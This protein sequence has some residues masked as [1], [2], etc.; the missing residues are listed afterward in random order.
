MSH[1]VAVLKQRLR[2]AGLDKVQVDASGT[3]Q[4]VFRVQ[5]S[6]PPRAAALVGRT[7]WLTFRTWDALFPSPDG[8]LHLHSADGSPISAASVPP[9]ETVDNP[10]GT[11]SAGSCDPTRQSCLPPRQMP[12]LTAINSPSIVGARVIP[13]VGQNPSELELSLTPD[14]ADQLSQLSRYLIGRRPPQNQ[15][16]M[17]ED[18][19]LL[20]SATVQDVLRSPVGM[21]IPS[22]E[23]ASLGY[24]DLAAVVEAGTLTGSVV[25]ISSDSI[26]ERSPLIP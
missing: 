10:D 23:A 19:D 8:K 16:A 14:A 12:A 9:G 21:V 20:E 6:T 2:L 11:E 24:S 13:S 18:G 7:G 5:D 25:L 3:N 17:F 22:L 15:L 4:A 1:D 26:R